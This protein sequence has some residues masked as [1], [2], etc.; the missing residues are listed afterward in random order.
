MRDDAAKSGSDNYRKPSVG[1]RQNVAYVHVI[2]DNRVFNDGSGTH[3][4]CC[5]A[6]RLTGLLMPTPTAVSHP[7]GNRL[8]AALP[9]AEC[10]RLI[11]HLEFV[12]LARGKIVFDAGALIRHAYFEVRE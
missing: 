6:L 7:A 9:R 5:L 12:H 11:P 3:L 2:L 10:E 1:R 8:L 4:Q